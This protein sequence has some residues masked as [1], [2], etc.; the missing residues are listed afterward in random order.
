LFG[1]LVAFAGCG[2][3]KYE[4]EQRYPLSGKI[5]FDGAP[6][7]L[8]S[9]TFLPQSGGK[10]RVSGGVIKDG[11]FSVTEGQGAT[12]GT[13]RIEIRWNKLT[14]KQKKD[15]DTEEMIDERAEGLPDKFHKNSTL[16]AEI[17]SPDNT[18][19]FDL[20]SE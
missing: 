15:P 8:G 4:G 11:A 10:G 19:N 2:G 7:D 5:T 20:K 3:V 9:I 17:P 6:F 1:W 14:G 16:T 18:Y 12:A 13:Y